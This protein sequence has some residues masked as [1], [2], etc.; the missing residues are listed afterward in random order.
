MH[1]AIPIPKIAQSQCDC[2]G[3]LTILIGKDAKNMSEDDAL[4]YVAAYTIGNDMSA[5]DR[6]REVGKAGPV[7]Q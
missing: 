5:R 3:E 7:P 1:E 2:E 6:Q 4:G